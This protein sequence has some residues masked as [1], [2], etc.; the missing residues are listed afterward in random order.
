MLLNDAVKITVTKKKKKGGGRA[1]DRDGKSCYIHRN[2]G[3]GIGHIG[4]IYFK[5][6]LVNFR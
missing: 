6:V 3:I 4:N 1:G 5:Y 2:L